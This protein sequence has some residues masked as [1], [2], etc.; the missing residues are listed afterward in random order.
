LNAS[1][2]F[3]D[4]ARNLDE[5]VALQ[6]C[7]A[8]ECGSIEA[9]GLDGDKKNRMATLAGHQPDSSGRSIGNADRMHGNGRLFG[10]STKK[11]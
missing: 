11:I 8:R 2:R 5:V 10:R 4:A 7:S 1:L 6:R 3:D 9:T